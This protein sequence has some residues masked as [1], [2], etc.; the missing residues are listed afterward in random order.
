M[1]AAG[2]TAPLWDALSLANDQITAYAAKYPEAKKRIIVISDGKDTRS[3]KSAHEVCW[4]LRQ[5][6][7]VV[8][9]ICLGNV[10]NW[11]LRTISYFLGSYRFQPH[12]LTTALA[13]CE[14]EHMLT[15]LERPPVKMPTTG[16]ARN[17]AAFWSR[18]INSR[19]Y[20]S[21][22]IMTRDA[23]P[24]RKAHPNFNDSFILLADSVRGV[25]ARRGGRPPTNN[26]R[27]GMNLRTMRLM[28]DMRSI[29]LNPHVHYDCYIS[30]T[31]MAFWKIVMEGPP[32][33]PYESGTFLLYLDIPGNFPAFPPKGRFSTPILHPNINR[34]GRICHSIFDRKICM[35]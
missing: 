34:H 35:P 15:Q 33:S 11:D 8:D 23:Y 13:I 20:A 22:T 24:E 14:M 6:Q 30:E 12:D 9:S 25:N 18:F 2:D 4:Q 1:I 29:V 32:E 16:T 3:T 28:Q 17:V 21:P 19:P 5:N 26:A 31:N 7:V 10:D 27:G